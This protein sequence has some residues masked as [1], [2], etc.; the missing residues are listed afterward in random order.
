MTRDELRRRVD[1]WIALDPDPDDEAALLR[2]RDAASDQNDSTGLEEL[3][4]APELTFGTAGL[5]GPM[6]PGP[7]GMNRANVRFA[8]LGVLG[9]IT[10]TGLDPTKGVVV[11]RDGRRHSESFND[12][13]V[14]VL[15]GGGVRVFE[16]PGPLPTPL[17]AYC[18]KALGATAGIMV[19]ASHNPPNDN[20][21]KL[22]ASD[23]AQIIPPDDEIVERHMRLAITN[24]LGDPGARDTLNASLGERSS[25]LRSYVADSVL[26]DY[27]GHLVDRFGVPPGEELA[28]TYTPLHGVGGV[29]MTQ[30]FAEAGYVNITRVERQFE[31]DGSFPTLPFPNPEEPGALDLSI[32]TARAANSTFILANDP[33]ADRLGA[34]VRI[35][36]EWRVLRG[37]EI[38]WLLAS[39]LVEGIQERGETM[40]TTIVSSTLLEKMAKEHG[41]AFATTLTG[42]KWLARAAGEGV[43]GFGY[44]EALGF[45]VDS[46]VSDK[47][48][49]SAALALARLDWELFAR[50]S[51]LVERLD[52]LEAAYGVHWTKQL[53]LRADGADGLMQLRQKVTDLTERPPRGLGP[54]AVTESA[55]LG[56]GF[57]G[58]RPTDGV[59]LQLGET[60]RVVVRPSGTEA[61]VKAYIEITPPREGALNEQRATASEIADA[62]LDS[63]R[64]LLRV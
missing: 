3:F 23:G 53:A 57:R 15:L 26:A 54:C 27:R 14:R 1:E 56:K 40:A 10:E 51:S 32:E 19:T 33:D 11:G 36:S 20:G 41:V 4:D 50:G 18:V 46:R 60:G 9:W 61:K 22:Y 16:M 64:E 17:V 38:G 45:A 5:R 58:L 34:A 42:F 43:L 59:W 7:G 48:G 62:V 29:P 47:D 37:D 13:V 8:T 35:G 25:S 12:E 49:M 52:E 21:Y 39:S 31:P 63:L 30:L 28:I 44:E 2:L 55:D 6:Q 24:A